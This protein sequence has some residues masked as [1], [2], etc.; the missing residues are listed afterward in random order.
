MKLRFIHTGSLFG[1]CKSVIKTHMLDQLI[2]IAFHCFNLV[3]HAYTMFSI[4]NAS[5]YFNSLI[6]VHCCTQWICSFVMKIHR[7][8][9]CVYFFLIIFEIQSTT[10]IQIRE[11]CLPKL[12]FATREQVWLANDQQ[13]KDRS[14]NAGVIARLERLNWEVLLLLLLDWHG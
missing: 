3:I 5:L 11:A 12:W 1:S 4:T 14:L 7:L 13:V 9:S 8:Y 6:C 2:W 10:W